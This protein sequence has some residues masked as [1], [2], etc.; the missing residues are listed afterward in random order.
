MNGSG[1][2]P[3]YLVPIAAF[4][5]ARAIAAFAEPAA[6]RSRAAVHF[7]VAALA[8]WLMR[9]AGFDPCA[10]G[11]TAAEAFGAV[12]L[13]LVGSSVGFRQAGRRAGAPGTRSSGPRVIASIFR[14]AL[15]PAAA[16]G[17]TLILAAPAA[18]TETRLLRTAAA[19]AAALWLCVDRRP[20]ET[21][22]AGAFLA[23]ATWDPAGGPASLLILVPASAAA[24]LAGRAF[25]SIADRKPLAAAA[26]AAALAVTAVCAVA[27]VAAGMQPGPA[28]FLCGAALGRGWAFRSSPGPRVPFLSPAATAMSGDALAFACGLAFPLSAAVPVAPA[29][30]VLAAVLAV[31]LLGAAL[32]PGP[33]ALRTK[34]A[35]GLPYVPLA[36]AALAAGRASALFGDAT[37]A[38]FAAAYVLAASFAR[39]GGTPAAEARSGES[40]RRV[41]AAVRRHDTLPGILSFAAAMGERDVRAVS[42][43]S[44]AVPYAEGPAALPRVE[45]AEETLAR[46]LAVGAAGG[47]RVLPSVVVAAGV[48]DGLAMAAREREATVVVLGWRR[49]GPQ[50]DRGLADL[51]DALSRSSPAMVA[52]VRHGEG[53]GSSRRLVVAAPAGSTDEPGF[54]AALSMAFRTRGGRPQPAEAWIVGGEAAGREGAFA[55]HV[56]SSRVSDCESWRDLPSAIKA[57][58]GGKPAFLVV[59]PRHGSAAWD[60][61][62]ERLPAALA[63]SFPDSPLVLLRLGAAPSPGGQASMVIAE[64]GAET[65]ASGNGTAVSEAWAPAIEAARAAGR[66][67]PRIS[68]AALVDALRRLVDSVFPRD[69]GTASRLTGEFSA[70]A[71][72]EPIE[73]APGVL[74]LHVHAPGIDLPTVAVGA[75]PEGWSLTALPR[76]VR[77][78][79]VLCSPSA[80][81]PGVHLAAL[82]QLARAVRDGGLVE[83]LLADGAV[84]E[85]S[86]NRA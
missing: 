56:P 34:L 72:K 66:V 71:R 15:V 10:L 14:A 74:L 11:T 60:P 69:P 38:G 3:T 1:A 29:A 22:L 2:L 58:G 35:A 78:I 28:A 27:A 8:G 12:A 48:A 43:A 76:R 42:V 20:V 83:R 55:P 9:E 18:G 57:R 62:A 23:A 46:A 85:F 68:D 63:E 41:L 5:L 81:G 79:I 44:S 36:F 54:G 21:V 53:F 50:A 47:M 32:A 75:R 24:F 64:S 26:P 4:L 61:T 30:M 80:A 52:S 82:A 70:T 39:D 67:M 7:A 33:A 51:A 49:T 86:A 77:V 59:V 37:V 73:L 40:G 16:L 31:S 84:E 25:A 17:L 13:F 6:G 45:E 19:L 65:V